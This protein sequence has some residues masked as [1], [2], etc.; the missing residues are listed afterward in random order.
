[1]FKNTA[2]P[3]DQISL[4]NVFLNQME[5]FNTCLAIPLKLQF[6]SIKIIHY[7]SII[8]LTCTFAVDKTV[9][10][11]KKKNWKATDTDETKFL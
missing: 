1:M 7:T 3:G 11:L 10:K 2:A 4:I 6:R 5:I 9:D 8:H